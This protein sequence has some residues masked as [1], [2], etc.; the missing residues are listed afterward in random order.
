MQFTE[1]GALR[2]LTDVMSSKST[3]QAG[4]KQLLDDARSGDT[5]AVVRPNRPGRSLAE[6]LSTSICRRSMRL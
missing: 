1:A 4:L 3:D 2:V 6:L 5:L